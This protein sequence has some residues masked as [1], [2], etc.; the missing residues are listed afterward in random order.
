MMPAIGGGSQGMFVSIY[1]N[2]IDIRRWSFSYDAATG[3]DWSIPLPLSGKKY[4][5][6]RRAA[7]DPAPE[8][9][10]G[11]KLQLSVGKG[12]SRAGEMRDFVTVKF[13]AAKATSATPRANDYEVQLE[14]R[15]DAVV[16]VLSTRRVYS[17][18]YSYGY[19]KDD[20]PVVCNFPLEDVP[21]N[22]WVRFV[23]R[24]VNSFQ[25]KGEMIVSEWFRFDGKTIPK[26]LA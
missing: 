25:R 2:A 10:P 26:N 13:P 21:V 15:R 4:S 9:T 11:V 22:D 18:G 1:E 17:P 24:P 8:F 6:S 12:K 23:A 5:H 16:R 3:P 19:E 14:N 20:K 7:E